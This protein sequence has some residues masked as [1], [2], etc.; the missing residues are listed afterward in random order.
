M[1]VTIA[2]C[3]WNRAPLLRRTLE[4][5]TQLRVPSGL[6][7]E[8]IVVA[9]CCTD[10]TQQVVRGMA[11]QLPIRIISEG[12]PGISNARNAAVDAAIGEYII[13][14]DDDVLVSADWLTAYARAFERYPEAAVFGGPIIPWFSVTVPKWLA[15]TTDIVGSVY[16]KLQPQVGDI[17]LGNRLLPFGANMAFLRSALGECNILASF[18]SW[19]RRN[20]GENEPGN[21][22]STIVQRTAVALARSDCC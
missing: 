20:D 12:R 3:T 14:A 15:E 9:N 5:M 10:T 19:L 2:I 13:M 22:R 11:T 18:L 8:L 21:S 7:W 17:P 16:G 6:Q 1:L 4:Q